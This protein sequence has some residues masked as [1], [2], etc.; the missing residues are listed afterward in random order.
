MTELE[1]RVRSFQKR[2]SS[3]I[4]NETIISKIT[5]RDIVELNKV[6]EPKINQNKIEKGYNRML[7]LED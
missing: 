1:K 2:S 4:H 6:I 7:Y 5:R 3:V